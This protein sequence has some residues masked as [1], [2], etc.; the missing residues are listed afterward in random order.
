MARDY[1]SLVAKEWH[2]TATVNV[3]GLRQNHDKIHQSGRLEY[4]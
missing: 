3:I 4:P 1:R 2:G